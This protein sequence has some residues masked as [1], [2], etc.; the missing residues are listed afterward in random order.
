[1]QR[2]KHTVQIRRDTGGIES[3]RRHSQRSAKVNHAGDGSAVNDLQTVG[4]VL[5][6]VELEV[7]LALSGTGNSELKSLMM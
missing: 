4:V 6:D 1:M 3:L 2:T 5:G 7:D